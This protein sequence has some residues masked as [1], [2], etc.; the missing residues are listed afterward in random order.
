MAY[1]KSGRSKEGTEA[2]EPSDENDTQFSTDSQVSQV[3]CRP[4]LTVTPVAFIDPFP[5]HGTRALGPFPSKF[6]VPILSKLFH[7]HDR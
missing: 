3:W 6:R 7:K 5:F 4:C 2:G 1:Q